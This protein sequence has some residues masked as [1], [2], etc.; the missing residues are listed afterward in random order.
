MMTPQ[1]SAT[2][3]NRMFGY[4][5]P[6]DQASIDRF[7][8]SNPAAASRMG[9]Y[10]ETMQQMVNGRGVSGFAEGGFISGLLG[11]LGVGSSDNTPTS[12][13]SQGGGSSQ[14][15]TTTTPNPQ[16]EQLQQGQRDLALQASQPIQPASV[17]Q[18]QEQ[19][20][21][22]TEGAGQA[23]TQAP[24]VQPTTVGQ[25]AQA[26]GPVAT[27]ASLMEAATATPAVQQETQGLQ[28]AQTTLPTEA[29][30]QAAQQ[31]ETSVSDVTA[32]QGTAVL[33]DN[34]VQRK[35]EQGELIDGS[36]ADAVTAAQFTEQI[37]AAQATP[38]KQAT[39]QGQ[40]EDLMTQFE[41]G[42]APAW[43]AGALR[44]ATATMAARGLGASSLAGQAVVQAAMEAALPIA[45]ADAQTQAEFEMQNLSNRQ[46]RALLAAQQRAA[47]IGMEFEQEFQAKVLNASKISDIANLNFTAE[48]QVALENSRAANTVN[49][50]NLSNQ[51][52][53]VMAEAA[54]LAN[55]DIAN[56]NN[57]QQA[58]VQN[59]QNFLQ[60]DMANLSNRQQ[61]E[62]FRTQQNIQALFTDQAAQ[63][64]ASQFNA[65]S[66]N[67]T[68]QFFKSLTQQANQFNTTQTNAI[69]QFN[70][71]QTN[72][73]EQFNAQ[74]QQQRDLFNAQNAL[75]I[76]QANAQWRQNV[77]TINTAAQNAANMEQARTV[78]ALSSANLAQIWQRERD[79]MSFAFTAE[80][81]QL[82]RNVQVL[83]GDKRLDEVRRQSDNAEETAMFAFGAR[84]LFGSD[85]LF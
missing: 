37:Q 71:G 32:A 27:P 29:Q 28:A 25:A 43:A 52:A 83:L 21:L 75:I 54:A 79:L 85:G 66:E 33:M 3:L 4:N 82:D 53:V 41:G 80:Q 60:V 61:T 42:D 20:G 19:P 63:N 2:I 18:I 62:L 8:A 48:Q 6:T 24:Q 10:Q 26:A 16:L 49:L 36:A 13:S 84:L 31:T 46:Q 44:T 70:A 38:T 30:V 35:I 9:R 64:A 81:S 77:S 47:F 1:Q 15:T 14:S 45:V 12:N 57:R 56:L 7:L 72:A 68:D 73:V 34:P 39:V 23:A 55:M 50:Q 22:M 76:E 58:A 11:R 65:T 40:L 78:N 17:A 59:A 69:A 74:Y 5:G 51:Q 67:Q